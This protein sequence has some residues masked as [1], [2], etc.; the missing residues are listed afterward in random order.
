MSERGYVVSG[1]TGA[2][3]RAVVRELLDAGQ[4]VAVPYRSAARWQELQ[5]ACDG[6]P[7]LWGAE[8]DVS[9]TA[10]MQRFCDQAASALPRLDGAVALAGGYAGSG[11]FEMAPLDE[12]T[13][14]L[15][16]NL[17]TARALCRGVLPH[18]LAKGGSVVTV[19]SK[20]AESG[21]AGASAYAVSKAGVLTLTRVLAL[22]NKDRGVRFN[23]IV[24]AT[25]DT[26][27][28]RQAMPKADTSSWT[29]PE[30]IARV[31][32]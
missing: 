20:L 14:M 13:R 4:R 2:L 31:V 23:C 10:A 25:I 30:A 9:D 26:P 6:S 29:S 22:E 28:N 24:P 27:A 8:A 12:W 15:K 32:A 18:L 16:D 1:A 19:A 21:G 17:E 3:G 11:S 7:L 5:A